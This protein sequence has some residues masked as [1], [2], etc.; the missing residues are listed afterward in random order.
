LKLACIA[1]GKIEIL[2]DAHHGDVVKSASGVLAA[3]NLRPRCIFRESCL[4]C[5]VPANRTPHGKG[6]RAVGR[7]M[8]IDDL[9]R[10]FGC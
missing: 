1:T 7:A 9:K 3:A 10:G 6:D 8:G 5:H 2:K 4:Q